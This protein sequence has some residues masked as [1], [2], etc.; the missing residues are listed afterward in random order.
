MRKQFDKKINKLINYRIPRSFE[1]SFQIIN[2]TINNLWIKPIKTTGNEHLIIYMHGGGF[3]EGSINSYKAFV[4]RI[5]PHLGENIIFVIPEYRLAPEHV[6]PAAI[7]DCVNVYKWLIE[8]GKYDPKKIIFMGDSAGGNLVFS[9]TLK[10]LEE[11]QLPTPGKLVALS[12]W[13]D[14]TLSQESYIR[15]NPLDPLCKT[16]FVRHCSGLAAPAESDK[17]KHSPLFASPGLFIFFPTFL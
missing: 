17:K 16:N 8:D 2:E 14:L 10:I 7:E 9:T 13:I 12:P 5:L 3:V 6:L 11:N 15:N 1:A 4:S